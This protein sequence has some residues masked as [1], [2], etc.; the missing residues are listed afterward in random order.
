MKAAILAFLTKESPSKGDTGL[1]FSEITKHLG[2]GAE[3]KVR[4]CLVQIVDDGDA[5]NTI[6]DDHFSSL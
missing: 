5:F 6:D 3:E 2:S 4:A 1:A